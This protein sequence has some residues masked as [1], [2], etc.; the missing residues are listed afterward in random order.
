MLSGLSIAAKNPAN[1]PSNERNSPHDTRF[2]A[3]DLPLEASIR[4]LVVVSNAAVW[5]VSSCHNA[6]VFSSGV[7]IARLP[8]H[9]NVLV[10]A[11]N[12]EEIVCRGCLG[13]C[14]QQ[15]ARHCRH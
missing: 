2:M 12:M 3:I 5:I 4:S 13:S 7:D 1:D 15:E 14:R 11:A 6:Q 9:D 8:L 10:G